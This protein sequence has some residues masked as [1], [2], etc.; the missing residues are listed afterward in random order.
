MIATLEFDVANLGSELEGRKACRSRQRF[1]S[2]VGFVFATGYGP[3][4]LPSDLRD[5]APILGKIDRGLEYSSTR[6][7]TWITSM[8]SMF[9]ISIGVFL[10]NTI[11]FSAIS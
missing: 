4:S 3:Q 1:G 2:G 7:I 6:E 8:N 5:V 9:G 10:P 11:D